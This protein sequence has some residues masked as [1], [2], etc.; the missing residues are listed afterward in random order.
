MKAIYY[1]WDYKRGFKIKVNN[2]KCEGCGLCYQVCPGH[3]VNF[4]RLEDMFIDGC[5]DSPPIGRFHSC[6][7]GAVKD[8]HL[9]WLSS[10]GG[11][12]TGILLSAVDKGMI[13][14][15]IVV[16]AA[17]DEP[18][19]LLPC[20]ARTKEEIR[21]AMGSRYLPVIQGS[22]LRDILEGEVANLAFVGLP[23]HIHGL[24][25]LQER[26]ENLKKKI[27]IT[28][29]LFCGGNYAPNAT[30][31]TLQQY[32]IELDKIARIKHRGNGWPGNL[33][34]GYKDKKVVSYPYPL[35]AGKYFTKNELHRCKLCPD[36]TNELA[37]ISFGDAWLDEYRKK[38]DLGTSIIVVRTLKGS[39]FLKEAG[40]CV[41]EI[42]ELSSNKVIK[43][44]EKML[45]KRKRSLP[46]R[47]KFLRMMK[48]PIPIYRLR[49]SRIKFL[50][51]VYV[52]NLFVS[53]Y[54]KRIIR[55]IKKGVKACISALHL[56]WVR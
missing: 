19:K 34:I 37:D 39:I 45:F 40:D 17:Q 7:V 29:G 24:R 26:D 1:E 42:H 52:L 28:I 46:I 55:A 49:Y 47:L 23:C 53:G 27:A 43:S 38:D 54:C 50:D 32:G 33:C 51:Y 3:E 44:Q 25:K 21:N 4:L 36:G 13:D 15:A 16:S 22:V 56:T 2:D 14:G 8:K 6:Y 9:R 48:Y 18:T 35:Y 10:S 31:L 41:M 5:N 12:V 20:I 30:I 11:I